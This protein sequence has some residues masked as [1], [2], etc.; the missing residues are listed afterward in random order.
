VEFYLADYRFAD[1]QDDYV[2]DAWTLW[3]L[4]SLAGAQRVYFN[5]ASTDVGENGMNTPSYFAI[6]DIQFMMV[7]EPSTWMLLALGAAL[8]SL[9]RFRR[10]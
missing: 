6:D 4:S 5:L 7:P 8:L 10:R 3:D 1:S 2:V 9:V